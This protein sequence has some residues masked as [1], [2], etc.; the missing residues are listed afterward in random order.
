M[1]KIALVVLAFA[2]IGAPLVEAAMTPPAQAAA[3]TSVPALESL[4]A[5]ATS[6]IAEGSPP[7]G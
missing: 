7:L 5:G 1:L 3:A 2:M 4:E 6:P